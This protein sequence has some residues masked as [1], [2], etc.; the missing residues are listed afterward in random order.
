[1]H[2]RL[3]KE[4][5]VLILMTLWVGTIAFFLA[6]II[7]TWGDSRILRL[8]LSL[9]IGLGLACAVIVA[10]PTFR[11]NPV[12]CCQTCGYDLTGNTSGRCPECGKDIAEHSHDARPS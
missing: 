9:F 10:I 7:L 6:G 8:S 11:D 1:V 3:A 12:G 5:K 4:H 2:V